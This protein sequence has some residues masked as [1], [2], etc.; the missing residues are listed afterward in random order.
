MRLAEMQSH[1]AGEVLFGTP[2]DRRGLSSVVLCGLV[3]SWRSP[4]LR[5]PQRQQ[6]LGPRYMAWSHSSFSTST[7]V[8]LAQLQ[9][10]VHTTPVADRLVCRVPHWLFRRSILPRL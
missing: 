7:V 5:I 4:D 9:A 2:N 8:V 1:R 10:S 3:R 6:P